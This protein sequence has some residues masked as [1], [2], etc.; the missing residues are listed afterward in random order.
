VT[1]ATLGKRIRF[2]G[3]GRTII[4]GPFAATTE[5]IAGF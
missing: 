2:D 1:P 5:V 4:D 3:L